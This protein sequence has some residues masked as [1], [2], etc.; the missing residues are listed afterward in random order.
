[1]LFYVYTLVLGSWKNPPLDFN[2]VYVLFFQV[3]LSP[4]HNL[5]VWFIYLYSNLNEKLSHA[6]LTRGRVC[7]LRDES[8]QSPAHAGHMICAER[9]GFSHA[10]HRKMNEKWKR[11]SLY[12]FYSF[13]IFFFGCGFIFCF[14]FMCD[15]LGLE[16]VLTL[17]LSMFTLVQGAVCVCNWNNT[18][19]LLKSEIMIFI[20]LVFYI[21]RRHGDLRERVYTVQKHRPRALEYQMSPSPYLMDHK[22]W[23]R[24]SL[25]SFS[26]GSTSL[27]CIIE[28]SKHGKTFRE[29]S[30]SSRRK[31][32][33][34]ENQGN[35]WTR[36]RC[37]TIIFICVHFAERKK[38]V[39]A[40]P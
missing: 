12:H 3:L 4:K 40:F 25:G 34:W 23:H 1:M 35:R 8:A 28:Y 39:W 32:G 37:S 26:V 7:V 24:I 16:Q 6:P 21:Y 18:T 22:N 5:I 17:H 11:V 20:I 13:S 33:E 27:S 2:F 19:S 31:K 29:R 15:D 9:R 10:N 14:N 38:K 30:S 36:G